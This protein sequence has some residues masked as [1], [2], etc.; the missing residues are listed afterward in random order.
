M[1]PV[2]QTTMAG[3]PQATREETAREPQDARFPRT[4]DAERA[5]GQT[6]T[7]GEPSSS[8]VIRASIAATSPSR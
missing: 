6:G 4:G 7:L 5:K 8:A 1:V 3:Q 2:T